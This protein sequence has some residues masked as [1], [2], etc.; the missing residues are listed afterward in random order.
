MSVKN[1]FDIHSHHSAYH[2]DPSF[3]EP[4]LNH[5]KKVESAGRIRVLD[6]GCGDGRFIKYM[7]EGGVKGEFYG[8]D[9]SFGM[10]GTARE[11]LQGKGV[12]LLIAD[13][14]NMPVKSG[15]EFDTI[16]IDMVLHHLI[17]KTR[18]KS[19]RLVH[20]MLGI[21]TKMLP[22]NGTLIIEEITYLSYFIPSITSFVIF[23]GLKLLNFLHLDFSKIT[24]QI[25]PR[26]EVNFFYDR[27][28]EKILEKYGTVQKIR[29]E[30]KKVSIGKR[31]LF[32]R[33]LNY[34]S[35]VVKI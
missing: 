14:F 18:S 25:Q 10:I 3:Y 27:Q 4:I 17:G 16:H 9:L 35:Y 23:Y 31:L 29:A 33:E 24:R 13:G 12:E 19:I 2:K 5:F 11:N 6:I 1:Y 28:L 30:P 26:L 34:L 15:T 21:L 8:I 7:I 22:E 32:L 20:R